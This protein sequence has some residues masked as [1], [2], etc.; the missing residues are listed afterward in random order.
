MVLMVCATIG[1][2]I[3]LQVVVPLTPFTALG[4]LISNCFFHVF[5]VQDERTAKH[6]AELEK[7]LARAQE[8]ERSRRLFFSIVSHDI[9]TPLGA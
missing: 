1:V 3:A 4:C 8:A 9:R 6:M 7:A 2:A 5:V